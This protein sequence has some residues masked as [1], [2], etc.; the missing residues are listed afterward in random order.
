MQDG[1]KNQACESTLPLILKTSNPCLLGKKHWPRLHCKAE[2]ST[3]AA[4]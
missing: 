1:A 3:T 2:K 4:D